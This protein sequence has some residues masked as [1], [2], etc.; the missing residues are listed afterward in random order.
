MKKVIFIAGT[1]YSGSTMI[2]MMLANDPKGYSLGEVY[3]L[4]YP[5]RKHHYPQI[6]ET[7]KED[8]WAEILKQ[9]KEN[10]YVKMFELFPEIDFFVDSSKDL[11]WITENIKYLKRNKIDYEVVLIHKTPEELAGSFYKRNRLEQWTRTYISYHSAFLTL[12]ENFHSVAYKSIITDDQILKDL[13]LSLQIDYTD[14]KKEFWAKEHKTFFGNGRTRYHI[15][16]LKKDSDSNSE[17]IRNTTRKKLNYD[18]NIPKCVIEDVNDKKIH[19]ADITEI[20]NIIN[21][22]S[23]DS[24]SLH[25][26]RQIYIIKK[27]IKRTLLYINSY[28]QYIFIKINNN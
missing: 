10:I 24:K 23:P 16:G 9:H 19:N 22:K 3:A 21:G 27:R 8:T 15:D 25:I 13:C 26:N 20:E 7:K 14:I 4:F 1:S 12:I 5:W 2:D 18:N 6:K 11:L 17:I 28:L